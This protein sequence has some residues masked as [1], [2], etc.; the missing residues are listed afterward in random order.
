ML[1]RWERD[2]TLDT[3]RLPILQILYKLI[4]NRAISRIY[5][6]VKMNAVVSKSRIR[7]SDSTRSDRVL[8]W[9]SQS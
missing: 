6:R 4:R 3:D 1:T 7:A 5:V 8:G 2:A 9:K